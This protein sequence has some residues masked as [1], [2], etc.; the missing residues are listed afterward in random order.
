MSRASSVGCL[1]HATV[2]YSTEQALSMVM[3]DQLP[4]ELAADSDSG[5][6]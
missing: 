4:N 6:V 2:R 3:D 5:S 1:S